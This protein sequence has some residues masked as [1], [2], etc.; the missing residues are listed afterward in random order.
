M[1][2]ERE[3]SFEGTLGPPTAP[4]SANREEENAGAADQRLIRDAAGR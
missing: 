4:P 2:R 3:G 1:G